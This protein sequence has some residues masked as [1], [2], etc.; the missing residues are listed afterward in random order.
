MKKWPADF[1]RAVVEWDTVNWSR[2]IDFWSIETRIDDRPVRILEVGARGGGLS[3]MFAKEPLAEGS[4]VIC[5]DLTA[6][7]ATAGPLHQEW[8]VAKQISYQAI[9]AI[10][11]DEEEKYDII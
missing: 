8:G 2:A 11:L 1:R 5:S 9:N 3:L 10:E 7:V 6:P 4:E